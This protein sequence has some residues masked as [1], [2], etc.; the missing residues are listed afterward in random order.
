METTLMTAQL[1]KM[2]SVS[3]FLPEE[4]A[5]RLK[6]MEIFFREE[7]PVISILATN[8]KLLTDF[9]KSLPAELEGKWKT[10]AFIT[11]PTVE[12]Y[13]DDY[14]KKVIKEVMASDFIFILTTALIICL[15]QTRLD[16]VSNIFFFVLNRYYDCNQRWIFRYI[17]IAHFNIWVLVPEIAKENYI[18]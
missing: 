3:P 17:N 13:S 15:I 18:K 11:E 9:E 2:N 6:T 16:A 8:K 14:L 7:K 5:S 12:E 10:N 4:I 1:A